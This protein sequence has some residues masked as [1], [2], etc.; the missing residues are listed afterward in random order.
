VA[1]AKAGDQV[2]AK[3]TDGLWYAASIAKIVGKKAHVVFEQ[4]GTSAEVALNRVDP[5]RAPDPLDPAYDVG[6]SVVALWTGG[7]WYSAEVTARSCRLWAVRFEDGVEAWVDE[8]EADYAAQKKAQLRELTADDHAKIAR[9]C[10]ELDAVTRLEPALGRVAEILGELGDV[11][12][13]RVLVSILGLFERCSEEDDDG[14]FESAIHVA[15]GAWQRDPT[16]Q[17]EL[18]ASFARKPARWSATM[19]YR[20][21]R[22]DAPDAE[23]V[24]RAAVGRSDLSEGC[25]REIASYVKLLDE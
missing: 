22:G 9:L 4:D 16:A 14:V 12:D 21:A 1:K 11:A 23:H 13:H 7:E 10:T 24:L 19:L 15:E 8:V 2:Y 6:M 20:S 3:W 18:N 5:I 17:Q 25:R